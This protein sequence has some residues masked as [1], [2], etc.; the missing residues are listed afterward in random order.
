M[1][2]ASSNANFLLLGGEKKRSAPAEE[3]GEDVFHF[4]LGVVRDRGS[5]VRQPWFLSVLPSSVTSGKLLNPPQFQVPV[6]KMGDDNATLRGCG[7]D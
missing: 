5:E 2:S 6:I 1:P 4:R 7:E 3:R